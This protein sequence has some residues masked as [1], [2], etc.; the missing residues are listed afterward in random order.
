ME[1]LPASKAFFKGIVLKIPI[2]QR[3]IEDMKDIG[4]N[5]QF[6]S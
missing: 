4:I 5:Q 1:N 3:L 6:C 2:Y